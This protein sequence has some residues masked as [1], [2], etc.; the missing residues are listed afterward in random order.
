MAE[1]ARDPSRRDQNGCVSRDFRGIFPSRAWA[2]VNG[3]LHEA[4]LTNE[5]SGEYHGFP[6][7]YEDQIHKIPRTS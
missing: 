5:V 7:Q 4:R 2:F 6:I 1:A 3:I